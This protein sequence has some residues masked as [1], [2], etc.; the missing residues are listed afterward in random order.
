MTDSSAVPGLAPG[1]VVGRMGSAPNRE[2]RIC[3]ELT[4][5]RTALACVDARSVP[6]RPPHDRP[7]PLARRRY[8]AGHVV[9][10]SARP[11]V[12]A[13]T[14]AVPAPAVRAAARLIPAVRIRATR[15]PVWRTLWP[16]QP[17]ERYPL[18]RYPVRRTSRTTAAAEEG[19]RGQGDRYHRGDPRG[20]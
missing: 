14:P 1:D 9:H 7:W 6:R 2:S 12:P 8:G 17:A 11:P 4:S 19:R 5:R 10:G 20:A 18:V 16:A 3:P 15:A 13:T